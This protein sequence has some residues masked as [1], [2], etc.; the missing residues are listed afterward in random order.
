MLV[1]TKIFIHESNS[2]KK[3]FWIKPINK[4]HLGADPIKLFFLHF[5]VKLVCL[6]QIEKNR[7]S[8]NNVVSTLQVPC[9]EGK[10]RRVNY[11]PYQKKA[12]ITLSTFRCQFH[13]HFTHAFFVQKC[14]T[15]LFS[16]YIKLD[17][18]CQ[19]DFC[20]KNAFVKHWW[21]WR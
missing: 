16:T 3:A 7:A 11:H 21:N 14:F 8:F 4:W 5:T 15:Q 10:I 19:K 1:S 20:M 2:F 17:K 13:Q 6:L 9:I 18:S 12:S